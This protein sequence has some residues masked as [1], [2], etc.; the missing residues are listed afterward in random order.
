M[1]VIQFTG[2]LLLMWSSQSCKFYFGFYPKRISCGMTCSLERSAS[3]V[4]EEQGWERCGR[5][6]WAPSRQLSLS[7]WKAVDCSRFINVSSTC[8]L[9]LLQHAQLQL[10]TRPMFTEPP[11]RVQSVCHTA[12][13]SQHPAKQAARDL[14]RCDSAELSRLHTNSHTFSRELGNW[15]RL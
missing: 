4:C 1:W 9:A 3:Y 5:R 8:S 15:R 13:W 6:Q 7:E 11:P 14:G 2:P 12:I 10:W